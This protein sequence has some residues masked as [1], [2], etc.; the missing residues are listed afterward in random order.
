MN[1]TVNTELEEIDLKREYSQHLDFKPNGLWYGY[2]SNWVNWLDSFDYDVKKNMIHIEINTT[3]L[4][5]I[6]TFEE[7]LS[8]I[9]SYIHEVNGNKCLRFI[10]WEKVTKDYSGIEILNYP[11]LKSKYRALRLLGEVWFLLWDIDSG[12]IWDLSILKKQ[13][14]YVNR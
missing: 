5:T 4:L 10:D 13:E 2:D 1:R 12:C 6:K 11:V 3:N 9:K 7:L 14:I 8:F